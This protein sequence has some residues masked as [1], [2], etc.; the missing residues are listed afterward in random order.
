MS[1]IM[2]LNSTKV[3]SKRVVRMS[4]KVIMI[5]TAIASISLVILSS[6][7][8]P[9]TIDIDSRSVSKTKAIAVPVCDKSPWKE[10]E[11]LVGSCSGSLKPYNGASSMKDC[12]VACC[13]SESC[14]SWQFRRDVGCLHGGDVRLGMEKDGTPS[15]CSD[16][17]PRKWEGQYVMKR[18]NGKIVKDKDET[19]GCSLDTWN[20]NE[21]PG[22]CF[23]LGDVKKT[24]RNDKSIVID[25]AQSCMEGCCAEEACGAW[26]WQSD[27]G[28]FYNARM[29]GCVDTSD[30]AVFDPFI[31][32]RK[33]QLSR[34][35]VDNK[36]ELWQ[37]M[38]LER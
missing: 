3:T 27:L 5:L 36:G 25:S 29:H 37:Q 20:P 4:A 32:R 30:P 12:A 24:R 2:V 38:Q 22:Q 34:K 33:F 8:F 21:Q 11:N 7:H 16:H 14:I 1:Q 13:D 35:Y 31:G 15:W 18:A 6:R 9:L 23:G 10:S 17:P 28:C 26:Q 19:G